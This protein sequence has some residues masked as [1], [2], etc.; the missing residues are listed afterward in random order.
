L[1]EEYGEPVG[2]RR[3]IDA[4]VRI[5]N[6]PKVGADAVY[7]VLEDGLPEQ[8]AGQVRRVNTGGDDF[9]AAHRAQPVSYAQDV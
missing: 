5:P 6:Q 8:T 4:G 9:L 1:N 2:E 3:V 7:L